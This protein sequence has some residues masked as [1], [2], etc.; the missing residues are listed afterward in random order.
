MFLENYL[1][2]KLNNSYWLNH[3]CYWFSYSWIKHKVGIILAN[4]IRY[5]WSNI[6]NLVTLITKKFLSF[7]NWYTI[8]SLENTQGSNLVASLL[9]IISI[10]FQRFY[11]IDRLLT[12]LL[13]FQLI[14]SINP[15]LDYQQIAQ[16][17]I[18]HR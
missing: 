1:K 3:F 17:K 15:L 4:A 13:L 6:H 11:I 16:L 12:A 7:R 5:I 8:F 10:V 14:F 18:C 9:I 2:L